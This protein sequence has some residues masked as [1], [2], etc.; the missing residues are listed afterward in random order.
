MS[1]GVCRDADVS[2]V[3]KFEA[4]HVW[5]TADGTVF[6]I[7]LLLASARIDR[8]HDFLAARVTEIADFIIHGMALLIEGR[9]SEFQVTRA[10]IRK[11]DQ[12]AGAASGQWRTAN[13][14]RPAQRRPGRAG[15]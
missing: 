15:V 8:D 4:D 7:L 2:V 1:L 11:L 6:N 14:K 3:V 9:R 13:G 5:T 10:N 12:P